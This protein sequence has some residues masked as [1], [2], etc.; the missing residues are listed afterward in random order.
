MRHEEI[1]ADAFAKLTLSLNVVGTR[2]DGYHEIDA[3]T[4]SVSEPY[5]SIVVALTDTTQVGVVVD[6]PFA[7]E[8][9]DGESNLA[10]RAARLVRPDGGVA[11]N[12]HK[13]IPPGGGLGGGSADAAAVLLGLRALT[14]ANLDDQALVALG[15][16]LGSDVPF[17]VNGGGAHMRGRGEVLEPLAVPSI[18][19][20]VATPPFGLSTPAVYR[21]WD[22]LG[23][24][25]CG[26]EVESPAGL[27]PVARALVNDLE[28]AAEHVEPRLREFR[29]SVERAAGRP[30]LLA[31]SGS[32][33]A[34]LFEHHADAARAYTRV[35]GLVRCHL[36]VG[37]TTPSGVVLHP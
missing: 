19:V 6:G 33:V 30:A 32:S 26:R 15:A 8:V 17:C 37:G 9:P 16:T 2:A 14:R 3:L 18:P 24:P 25:R 21:A 31:G 12:L 36:W 10:A 23:G 11:I 22:E 28:P 5:D 20:L 7:A 4:V 34:V 1:R 13:R 29:E 27:A 35:G